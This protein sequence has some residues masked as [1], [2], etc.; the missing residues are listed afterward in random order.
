MQTY[1]LVQRIGAGTLTGHG[2]LHRYAQI[3]QYIKKVCVS[4]EIIRWMVLQ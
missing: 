4:V 3:L 1:H 2:A